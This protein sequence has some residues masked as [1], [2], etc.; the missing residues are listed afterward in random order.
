MQGDKTDRIEDRN[1]TGLRPLLPPRALKQQLPISDRAAAT[2]IA[3]RQGIRD[4][5]HG[6]DTERL[7]VIVGPCSI[8]DP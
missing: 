5:I 3:G 7:L 4:M 8:H 2:V 1:L 6:R